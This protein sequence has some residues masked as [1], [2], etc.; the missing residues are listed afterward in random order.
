MAARKLIQL[1][2]LPVPVPDPDD[3]VVLA[4]VVLRCAR[5]SST[6]QASLGPFSDE[7]PASEARC[8]HCNPQP[9]RAA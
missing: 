7:I 1:R 3:N 8:P 9:P 2:R 4:A 5:C 6:W